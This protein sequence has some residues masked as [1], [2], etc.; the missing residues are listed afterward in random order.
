MYIIFLNCLNY[1][2]FCPITLSVLR[3]RYTCTEDITDSSDSVNPDNNDDNNGDI[4]SS[5]VRYATINPIAFH[6]VDYLDA[7]VVRTEI[8]N[9]SFSKHFK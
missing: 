9:E 1:I 2:I 4:I 7:N 6:I 8:G 5:V 3:R